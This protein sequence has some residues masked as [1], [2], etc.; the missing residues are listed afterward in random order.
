MSNSTGLY[1]HAGR[2][3]LH[4]AIPPVP[5]KPGDTGEYPRSAAMEFS[6]GAVVQ[7]P[8]EN[9]RP[10]LV[11]PSQAR[12]ASYVRSCPEGLVAD[13]V[14]SD[15]LDGQ[16]ALDVGHQVVGQ[17]AVGVRQLIPAE[18]RRS[19]SS[20]GGIPPRHEGVL[21]QQDPT[22]TR[23]FGSARDSRAATRRRWQSGCA[24]PQRRSRSGTTWS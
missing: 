12:Y 23:R 17:P 5:G 3:T 21:P 9:A 15:H 7:S 1:Q 8:Y 6:L 20:T 11:W 24:R 22:G 4:G 10:A 13:S 16:V 19:A 2:P 18:P 14:L